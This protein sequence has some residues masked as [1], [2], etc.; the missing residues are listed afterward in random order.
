M[1]KGFE[2]VQTIQT[3]FKNRIEAVGPLFLIEFSPIHISLL[4]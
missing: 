2:I 4:L 1:K 3:I